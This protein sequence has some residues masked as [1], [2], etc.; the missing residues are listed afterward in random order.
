M[1]KTDDTPTGFA[2]PARSPAIRAAILDPDTGDECPPAKFDEHGRLLN[3]EE[4]IGEIVNPDGAR[5]LRGLLQQPRGQRRAHARRQV[6]DRRPRLPR[7]RRASSTSRAATRDWLR[8]DGENFAAAPVE[9]VLA[10]HPDVVLAAV[11]AVPSAEVGD[12][13]MVAL[14]LHDGAAFDADG[15]ARVPRRAA[16]PVTE[17][18]AAL[19]AHLRRPAVDRDAEGAEARAAARALGVRRRGVVASRPRARVPA[20][21]RR[22]RRRVARPVRRRATA[23]ISSDADELGAGS[24]RTPRPRRRGGGRDAG[25]GPRDRRRTRRS[26]RDGGVHGPDDEIAPVRVQPRRDDRRDGRARHR[27]RRNRRR[28]SPSTISSPNRLRISRP[29]SDPITVTSTCWSTTSGARSS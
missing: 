29:G 18:D 27:A 28:D 2:R 25:R 21:H 3:A 24:E 19:R 22:R 5:R 17:V 13:V 10:R 23:S 15:F 6:L 4:A 8:V 12:E 1:S 16:G 11:Y 7:R 9:Q 14:H 26:G 20:A